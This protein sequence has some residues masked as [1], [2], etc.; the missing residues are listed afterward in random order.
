MNKSLGNTKILVLIYYKSVH[1][2]HR[3]RKAIC[4]P[5]SKL[6]DLSV[7]SQLSQKLFALLTVNGVDCNQIVTVDLSLSHLL[8]C[9]SFSLSLSSSVTL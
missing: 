4:S 9:L 7:S 8:D 2:Y 1:Q 5:L 6:T 3:D